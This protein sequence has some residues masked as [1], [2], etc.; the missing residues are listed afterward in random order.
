[1]SGSQPDQQ[2]RE[3]CDERRADCCRNGV[4]ACVGPAGF[5]EDYHGRTLYVCRACVAEVTGG[6]HGSTE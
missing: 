4:P 1:M 2:R 3:R 6:E 5:D